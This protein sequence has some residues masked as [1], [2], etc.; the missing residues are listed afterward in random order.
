MIEVKF[1][2]RAG[3]GIL[4]SS[5]LL[6]VAAFYDKKYAQ[7]FP[8]FGAER[9]GA[10]VHSFLRIDNKPINL[11]SQIYNPDY[12][13]ILDDSLI[14]LEKLNAKK[15]I[16]INSNKKFNI[17]GVKTKVIDCTKEGKYSNT[18]QIA[19]FIKKT[20]LISLSSFLKAINEKFKSEIAKQN[21]EVAKKFYKK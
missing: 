16:F 3:H 13:L 2:G 7:S 21:I 8:M 14:K 6:A 5:Y 4:T 10:P 17:K 1:L 11:R 19:Y 12:I 15:G 18:A 20:K 9:G